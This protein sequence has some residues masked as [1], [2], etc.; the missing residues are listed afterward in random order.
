MSF[1]CTTRT[2]WS[3]DGARTGCRASVGCE[4]VTARYIGRVRDFEFDPEDGLMQ[5]LI[6]DALGLPVVPEEVV[7]TYAID[8]SEILSSGADRIIVA[9]GAEAARRAAQLDL[10]RGCNSPRRLGRTT[11]RTTETTTRATTRATTRRSSRIREK[12]ALLRRRLRRVRARTAYAESRESARP[13][14]ANRRPRRTFSAPWA[15]PSGG[16]RTGVT[17]TGRS[18]RSS[19]NDENADYADDARPFD[20]WVVEEQMQYE[21]EMEGAGESRALRCGAKKRRVAA[22]AAAGG[23]G[24]GRA[25]PATTRARAGTEEGV[26]I[27][28]AI[29]ASADML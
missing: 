4:V 5:R 10:L 28:Q 26:G 9:E 17:A 24:G 18:S 12:E 21:Y 20:E 8:V 1:W 19:R 6:V 27:E 16:T 15:V 29:D 13:P 22:A 14:G 23:V 3:A 25:A 2:R 7:S 11:S